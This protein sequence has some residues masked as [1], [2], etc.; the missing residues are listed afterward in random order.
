MPNPTVNVNATSGGSVISSNFW[1]INQGSET[2]TF[3]VAHNS[4]APYDLLLSGSITDLSNGFS[5]EPV[6]KSGPGLMVMS[7]ANTYVGPTSVS[8]GTL[9]VGNGTSGESP[10]QRQHRRRQRGRAGLQP[11]RHR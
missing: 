1:P 3:N 11:G 8:G 7:G 5:G 4:S 10:H 2:W 9:E 6:I